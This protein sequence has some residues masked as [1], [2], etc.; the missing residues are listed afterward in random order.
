MKAVAEDIRLK[1]SQEVT[2][3]GRGKGEIR[4]ATMVEQPPAQG[5]NVPELPWILN[6]AVVTLAGWESPGFLIPPNPHFR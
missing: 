3:S 2:V 5:N 1:K 6:K 4:A